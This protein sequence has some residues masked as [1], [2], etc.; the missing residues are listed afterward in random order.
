MALAMVLSDELA[1][2][3]AVPD[4]VQSLRALECWRKTRSL[5]WAVLA[6]AATSRAS[7][8]V[9]ALIEAMLTSVQ[10]FQGL[11]DDGGGA[12]IL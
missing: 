8:H 9:A 11:L 6:A 7:K 12:A 1:E 10:G 5:A 2:A 4:E 3:E